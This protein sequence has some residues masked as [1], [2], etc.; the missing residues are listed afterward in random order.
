M[1]NKRTA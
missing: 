1:Q